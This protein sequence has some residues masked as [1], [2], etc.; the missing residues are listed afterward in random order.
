MSPS[1][2]AEEPAEMVAEVAAEPIAAELAEAPAE[3]AVEAAAAELA[4]PVPEGVVE[5]AVQVEEPAAPEDTAETAPEG[6]LVEE[7]APIDLP[8]ILIPELEDLVPEEAPAAVEST[9]IQDLPE[10]VWSLRRGTPAEPGVIRFAEDID[11]LRGFGQRRGRGGGGRKGK[12]RRSK[13][14]RRR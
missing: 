6:V 10:D 14:S 5:E 11:E 3:E 9:S 4:A 8:D 1:P 12:G 2:I 13:A 7:P